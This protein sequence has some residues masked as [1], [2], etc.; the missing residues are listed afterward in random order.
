MKL[1][2]FLN[3]NMKIP[4]SFYDVSI[5]QI[6]DVLSLDME[7]GNEKQIAQLCILLD[8]DYDVITKLSLIELNEINE[9]LNFLKEKPK[10]HFNR[11]ITIDNV[12]YGFIPN[13]DA[14]TLGE[15]V[16]LDSYLSDY[17][18]NKHS[19]ASILWRPITEKTDIY[20]K[21]KDYNAAETQKTADVF[22]QKLSYGDLWGASV[23]FC[24]I[25]TQLLN[26]FPEHLVQ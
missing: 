5:K 24:L 17:D 26:R 12:E 23:F 22:Y 11:Q 3:I 9:S 21:I 15:W 1:Q 8:E 7:D 4:K 6:D 10:N 19:I 13:L 14:I 25:G 16:D 18:N 2:H 20:Y